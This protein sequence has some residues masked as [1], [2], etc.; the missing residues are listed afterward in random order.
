MRGLP[1]R[2]RRQPSRLYVG[3]AHEA[4]RQ[5]WSSLRQAR[6]ESVRIRSSVRDG[7]KGGASR[8][9]IRRAAA[10]VR[11]ATSARRPGAAGYPHRQRPPL[12]PQG[13]GRAGERLR[14]ERPRGLHRL[15]D[16]I[17]RALPQDRAAGLTALG[18]FGE[19]ARLSPTE[20]RLV[21]ETAVAASGDLPLAVL[22][23]SKRSIAAIRAGLRGPRL[24]DT[25][26]RG[27]L[28]HVSDSA[29]MHP[30]RGILLGRLQRARPGAAR[31]LR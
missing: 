13:L 28:H 16:P 10:D 4:D 7:R 12:G 15:F 9:G 26:V 3:E 30:V 25:E 27:G 14:G 29:G 22:N 8:P 24:G 23:R 1:L 6:H 5:D 2:L 20:R 19:A 11:V 31:R 21:V 18:L 17:R